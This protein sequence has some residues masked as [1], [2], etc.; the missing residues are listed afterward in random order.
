MGCY[1]WSVR[2]WAGGDTR[3]WRPQVP[4]GGGIRGWT[5]QLTR[6]ELD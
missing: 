6:P 4:L 5:E 3:A 1:A 2:S